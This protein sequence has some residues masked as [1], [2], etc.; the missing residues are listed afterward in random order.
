MAL[1]AEYEGADNLIAEIS[2]GEEPVDAINP[3]LGMKYIW[4]GEEVTYDEYSAYCS[5]IFAAEV[6]IH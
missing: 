4:N 5:K 6:N 3:E 1:M 2:F